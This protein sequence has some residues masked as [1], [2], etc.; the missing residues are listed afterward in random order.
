VRRW[1]GFRVARWLGTIYPLEAV[2]F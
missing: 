2:D 1:V